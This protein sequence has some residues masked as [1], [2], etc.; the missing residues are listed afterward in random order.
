MLNYIG[1]ECYKLCRKK[2]LFFGMAAL[3]GLEFLFLWAIR[4]ANEAARGE[5]YAFL[6]ATLPLGLLLAPAFAAAVFD[7]QYRNET[8]KNE[9]TF[10]ISRARIYLGKLGAAILTGT[11]GGIA[12]VGW[13]LLLCRIFFIPGGAEVLTLTEVLA[14]SACALPLWIAALSFSFL[15]L[16]AL[17]SAAGAM[18]LAY[19]VCVLGTPVALVG[20]SADSPLALRLFDALFYAAPFR[21]VYGYQD[22][23]PME[24]FSGGVTWLY[25]WGLGA[26]W[27][28]V[29]AAVGLSVFRRRELR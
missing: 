27:A 28:A 16:M 23:A 2:G 17:R 13:Y 10:G 20:A 6:L 9:V 18:A 29:T 7:D 5:A 26:G 14:A 24:L 25:C 11:A 21:A 12:A 22:W 8:L 15:L 3:L 4:G 19:L 1:A